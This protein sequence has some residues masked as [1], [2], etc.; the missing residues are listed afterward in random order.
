[1][2]VWIKKFFYL[3]LLICFDELIFEILAEKS[4][5]S[6]FNHGFL[7]KISKKKS[8]F[9][10]ISILLPIVMVDQRFVMEINTFVF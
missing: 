9:K 3:A 4:E 5:I 10:K 6:A 1:M 8:T 2:I 7:N